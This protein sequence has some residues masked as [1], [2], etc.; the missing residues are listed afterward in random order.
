MA[1]LRAGTIHDWFASFI[2]ALETTQARI[3]P[4]LPSAMVRPLRAVGAPVF[5]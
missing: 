3:G 2:A 5:H 4:N 1:K